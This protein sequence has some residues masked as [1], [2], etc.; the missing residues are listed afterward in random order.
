MTND[1]ENLSKMPEMPLLKSEGS[2]TPSHK[3]EEELIRELETEE[4]SGS[5]VPKKGIEVEA[6]RQGWYKNFK[7]I[8]GNIFLLTD[9]KDREGKVIPAE[10][11]LGAWM[12]CTDPVIE[13]RHQKAMR[14]KRFQLRDRQLK[15]A[16]E[17]SRI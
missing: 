10:K 3:S 4:K 2:K 9:S 7:R 13:K 16:K 5:I 17:N 6:L 15:E 12:K 14:D 11:M 8:P 1:Q